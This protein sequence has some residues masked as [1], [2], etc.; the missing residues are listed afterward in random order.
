MHFQQ[1][2]SLVLASIA[3]VSIATPVSRAADTL[4]WTDYPHLKGKSGIRFA[5]YVVPMDWDH[6]TNA[7]NVTLGITKLPARDSEVSR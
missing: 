1:V 2:A 3:S 4:E 5:S 6:P 7:G